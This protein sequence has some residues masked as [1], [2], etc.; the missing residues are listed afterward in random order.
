MKVL[1]SDKMSEEGIKLFQEAEGIEVDVKTGLAPEE[2]AAI[3]GD[4]DALAIRSATKVTA[5]IIEAGKKL[6]VVGRAGIG[7]DNVD[8]SA[9]SKRGIVV[10]NTPLGNTVT[11]AEHTITM[12]LALSRKIPQAVASLKSRKWEKSKFSGREVQDKVLGIVGLGKIGSIVADRALGLKMRVIGYDPFGTSE[13]A[14]AMGVTLVTLDELLKQSDYVTVHT[15]KTKDTLNLFNKDNIAKMKR[16]AML[17]NCARGGIVNEV[18][19]KEALESGQLAGAALDVFETEPPLDSPLLDLD[20]LICTPHLGAST[21]EAQ[22]NVAVSVAEQIIDY[23]KTGAIKN[24]VNVPSVTAEVMAKMKPFFVLAEKMGSFQGQICR[25]GIKQIEITYQGD[26]AEQPTAPLTTSI[27]VGILSPFMS[28]MVNFVN[29]PIIAAER[30]I[31]VLES[32]T[33]TVED[34]V[35]MISIKVVTSEME[36]TLRGTIFGTEDPRIVRLNDFRLEAEPQGHQLLIYNHDKPGVIGAICTV[37]GNNNIN[38]SQMNVGQEPEHK[39]NVILLTTNSV[40]PESIM[41]II[42]AQK[43]I[44]SAIQLNL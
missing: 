26:L 5:A 32:K 14:Q 1:V 11:T 8:I 9:A 25:G 35:N 15:P 40:I 19:L 7:L 34:F 22:K 30:G 10:M 41:Q 18:D 28:H 37:L 4:Y 38:I 3:I 43:H 12:M 21:V 20:N 27:I 31:K 39:R 2:L 17:I 29:A 42:K 16:G 23:L 33:R 36:T 24:A 13:A 44:D 6:K